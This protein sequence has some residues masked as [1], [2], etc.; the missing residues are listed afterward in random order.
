MV[1]GKHAPKIASGTDLKHAIEIGLDEAFTA[2]EESFHDLTDEQIRAFPVDGWYNIAWTV[3]HTLD[4]LDS[5]ACGTPSGKRCYPE[6]YRW[7]LWGAEPDKD[8]QADDAFPTRGEM[9]DRLHAI[10]VMAMEVLNSM[11]EAELTEERSDH[12][13]K[14]NLADF[15]MRTIYHTMVHTRWIWLLRGAQGLADQAKPEQHWA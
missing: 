1:I 7:D 13:E 15:Y 3:M 4:N 2:L 11:T 12:P 6:E 8:P 14:E 5:Y 10:Q 9:L